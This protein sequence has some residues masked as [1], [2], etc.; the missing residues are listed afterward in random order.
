MP[1]TFGIILSATICYSRRPAGPSRTGG[2]ERVRPRLRASARVRGWLPPVHVRESA[3]AQTE[4]FRDR[5]LFTGA[6]AGPR[7]V[8]STGAWMAGDAM[9]APSVKPSCVG[10]VHGQ[11]R[12]IVAGNGRSPGTDRI[13]SEPWA[14]TRSRLSTDP[15]TCAK[16][17]STAE[18]YLQ[19]PWRDPQQLM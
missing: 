17:S 1:E 8:R 10:W 11:R 16:C 15:V 14:K 13:P 12:Q 6:D 4:D 5:T 9:H 7:P 19:R 18:S 2:R 3:A